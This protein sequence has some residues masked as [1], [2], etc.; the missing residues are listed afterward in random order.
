MCCVGTYGKRK[1]NT[2][3]AFEPMEKKK[4]TQVV[5]RNLWKTKGKHW[6]CIGTNRKR[7][8]TVF[9]LGPMEKSLKHVLRGILKKTKGKHKLCVGTN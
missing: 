1:D 6:L 7:Q 2:G 3:F 5:L 4:K 8:K 9:A